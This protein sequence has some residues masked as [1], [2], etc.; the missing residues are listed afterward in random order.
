MAKPELGYIKIWRDIENSILWNTGEKFSEGQAWIQF[1]LWAEYQDEKVIQGNQLFSLKAGE[2]MMSQREMAESLNW[3]QPT[4][5][6]W[7]KKLVS[8]DQIRTN[9]ESRKTRVSLVNYRYRQTDVH[10]LN[11]HV[12][13][14]AKKVRGAKYNS[15]NNYNNYNNNNKN[16]I[17]K[18]NLSEKGKKTSKTSSFSGVVQDTS[19]IK[20][21]KC[22]T[23]KHSAKMD[24]IYGYYAEC[25]KCKEFTGITQE[26]YNVKNEKPS[27]RKKREEKQAE[28]SRA[29]ERSRQLVQGILSKSTQSR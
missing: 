9:N 6:R 17:N 3:S 27:E 8:L 19:I 1:I 18:S 29:S 15:Y 21:G 2:F 26:D 5:N 24:F 14:K 11:R 10:L 12:N 25:P 4:L 7:L 20:N 13:Q 28:R 16:N 22:E 23:C